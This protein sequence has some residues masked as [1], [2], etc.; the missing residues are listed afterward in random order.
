M[1]KKRTRRELVA[2]VRR[3]KL[4]IKRMLSIRVALDGNKEIYNSITVAQLHTYMR[5]HGWAPV[6]KNNLKDWELL[7]GPDKGL[8][9]HTLDKDG[10]GDHPQRMAEMISLMSRLE[11]RS[12]LAVLL[13]LQDTKTNV[14][15]KI[16]E[17]VSK[18]D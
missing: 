16:A 15:D 1:E 2:E 17:A 14:L 13:A 11:R 8:V 3:L 10:Y 4:Q 18:D 12:P 9:Y 5:E 7:K 6:R